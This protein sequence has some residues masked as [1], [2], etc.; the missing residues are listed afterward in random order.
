VKNLNAREGSIMKAAIFQGKGR[1]TMENRPKPGI[2]QATEAIVRVVR[3]CVCG[4]DLWYFRG[5]SDH[6]VGAIGH[7]FIGVV[8]EVGPGVLKVRKGD[9]VIAP[10]AF[11]DNT[12]PHCEAGYHTSCLH[13]GFFGAGN[14][15]D[16]GQAEFVRVPQAD[17]TL[18]VVPKGEYDDDML[19]SLLSLSDVMGTG[20][21]AAMSAEVQK[22]DTVAVVGDGAVGLCGIIAAKLLGAK[23]IIALSRHPARQALAREF[24]A[25]IIVEE[26]G[27]DAVKRVL[28]LTGGIGV[29]AVLE[30]VGTDEANQT[31]F[32]IA[33]PGAVIGRVGVPHHVEISDTGTFFRNVGMRGGP[34]PVKAYMDVLL[35]AVLEGRIKPGKVFDLATDL[36]H[37]QEAY[38]AMDERRAVKVL[39]KVSELG[40]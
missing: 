18:E 12:C 3:S 13:G 14:E 16:G 8:E 24:G 2:H 7:E 38:Q 5:E 19:A 39:L 23:Q 26:R 31:A 11:S 37:I 36:D 25:R 1:I 10:F 17:G 32:S 20:Y 29:D 40:K 28:E 30:C 6:A 27:Q 4:S 34:A 22:G 21:H 33:R 35:P 9:F 15:A